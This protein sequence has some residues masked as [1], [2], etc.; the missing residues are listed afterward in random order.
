MPQ[1]TAP[2]T[3]R[4]DPPPFGH[5]R[6]T[7]HPRAAPDELPL[8]ADSR[9]AQA[10]PLMHYQ[11]DIFSLLRKSPPQNPY[12]NAAPPS[13]SPTPNSNKSTLSGAVSFTNRTNSRANSRACS[14]GA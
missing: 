13:S 6:S 3:V 12:G 14:D 9:P 10:R 1:K 4:G 2:R 11:S 8:V 7:A 5:C